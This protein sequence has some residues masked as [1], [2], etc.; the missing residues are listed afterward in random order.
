MNSVETM[1]NHRHLYVA[2][3]TFMVQSK[4][5]VVDVVRQVGR[6]VEYDQPSHLQ[7]RAGFGR[8]RRR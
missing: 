8:C 1:L 2:V 6:E 5:S 3:R 7:A 4:D